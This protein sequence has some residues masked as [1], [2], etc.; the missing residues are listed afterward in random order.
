V[1]SKTKKFVLFSRR[2]S[3]GISKCWV[4]IV[5]NLT[6]KN[7][8]NFFQKSIDKITFIWYYIYELKKGIDK[9]DRNKSN[10]I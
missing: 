10:S 9:N 7:F 3:V 8:L 2:E 4:Q 1:E 6:K 5:K